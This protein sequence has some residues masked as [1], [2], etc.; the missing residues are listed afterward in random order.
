V[1]VAGAA[2]RRRSQETMR[3]VSETVVQEVTVKAEVV[4][5]AVS[6]EEQELH[7]RMNSW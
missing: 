4:V 5:V 6:L 7:L 3:A 1:A 2:A